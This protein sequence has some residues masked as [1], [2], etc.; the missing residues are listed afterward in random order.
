MLPPMA[1]P[2][3]LEKAKRGMQELLEREGLPQP[4]EVEYGEASI[5]LVWWEEKFAVVVD[6]D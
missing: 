4:D 6:V 2:E 3:Q 5:R 1:S